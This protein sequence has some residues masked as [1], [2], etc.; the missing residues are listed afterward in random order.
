MAQL[1]DTA[2]C[3]LGVK[4][5]SADRPGIRDSSFQPN[6]KLIDWPQIV[7]QLADHLR[8]RQFRILAIS[9]GALYAYADACKLPERVL[10]VAIASGGAPIVYLSAHSGL[11][12]LYRRL[13]RPS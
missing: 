3:E 13:V 12:S 11:L 7:E 5:I 1:T 6:R 9:G 8:I 10:A 2:A 4:I